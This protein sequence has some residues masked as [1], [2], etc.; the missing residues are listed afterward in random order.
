MLVVSYGW[1]SLE[2]GSVM[3]GIVMPMKNADLFIEKTETDLG[4]I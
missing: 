1:V 3:K 2:V 4:N